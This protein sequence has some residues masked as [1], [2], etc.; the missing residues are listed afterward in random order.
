MRTRTLC[1]LC[2]SSPSPVGSDWVREL[3]SVSL[4]AN[5]I[6]SMVS[7]SSFLSRRF[8]SY[9][10]SFSFRVSLADCA[11][12][13]KV[14]AFLCLTFECCWVSRFRWSTG[15]V[16]FPFCGSRFPLVTFLFFVGLFPASCLLHIREEMNMTLFAA[17]MKTFAYGQYSSTCIT[18]ASSKHCRLHC[19][20]FCLFHCLCFLQKHCPDT[21]YPGVALPLRSLLPCFEECGTAFLCRMSSQEEY[22]GLANKHA[23][24]T[25]L[26]ANKTNAF[27]P[28]TNASDV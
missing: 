3:V 28:S 7:F 12:S 24:S 25:V 22:H 14:E 2:I 4:F 21:L 13:E 6:F 16:C 9:N 19:N 26:P 27:R 8:L 1:L 20:R 18:C 5:N 17:G 15:L 10:D 23:Q 11:R